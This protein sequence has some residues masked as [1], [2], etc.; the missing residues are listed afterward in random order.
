MFP[1][2]AEILSELDDG[3]LRSVLVDHYGHLARALYKQKAIKSSKHRGLEGPE[4]HYEVASLHVHLCVKQDV[5]IIKS[6]VRTK[7][8]LEEVHWNN[9]TKKVP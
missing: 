7:K 2:R 1:R 5:Q 3:G 9:V 4:G 8:G 6:G